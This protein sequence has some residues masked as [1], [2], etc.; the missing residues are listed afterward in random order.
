[1]QSIPFRIVWFWFMLYHYM[2]QI[3]SNSEQ[4]FLHVLNLYRIYSWLL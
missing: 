4:M 3:S 1:M 2:V